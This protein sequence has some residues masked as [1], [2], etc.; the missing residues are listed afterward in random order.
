MKATPQM[1]VT[2]IH[3]YLT[4]TAPK[5][6]VATPYVATQTV[7]AAPAKDDRIYLTKKDSRDL[8]DQKYWPVFDVVMN[9]KGEQRDEAI[10]DQMTFLNLDTIRPKQLLFLGFDLERWK[11]SGTTLKFKTKYRLRIPNLG[12]TYYLEKI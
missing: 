8:I 11:V 3:P 1:R 9:I 6:Q 5:K 7:K 4:Y 10:L 2:T 12:Y